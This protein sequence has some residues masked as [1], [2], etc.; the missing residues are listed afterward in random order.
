MSGAFLCLTAGLTWEACLEIIGHLLIDLFQG[1]VM[2]RLKFVVFIIVLVVVCAHA[3][4]AGTLNVMDYGA[5]ADRTTDDTA[6]IQAA[7]DESAKT[8]GSTVFMP[9]GKYRIEGTIHVREGVTLKGEF[10]GPATQIGTVLESV[11]GRGTDEGEGCIVMEPTST[12]S[13]IAIVY[14]EQLAELQ[15][16]IKYPFAVKVNMYCKVE[17]VGLFNPYQGLDLDFAHASMVRNVW[18]EPLKT[19]IY[20]DHISDV[21]R[22]ENVHFWPYFTH[23]KPLRKWVQQNGTAFEFGRSDWHY[24]RDCFSFGYKIGYQFH[25]SEEVPDVPGGNGGVTNG[26]FTG[27]GA[28]SCEIGVDVQSCHEVGISITNSMF[29]PFATR[30]SC[31]IVL[32]DTN[33]GNVTLTN[34]NFWEVRGNAAKVEGGALTL[35]ACNIHAWGVHDANEK[36][37]FDLV[38]GR[39]NVTGCTVNK[40]GWFAKLA[41]EKSR[42]MISSNMGMEHLYVTSSI[43][44]RAV[45]GANSPQIE[46]SPKIIGPD[47]EKKPAKDTTPAE[48]KKE[49]TPKDKEKPKDE[50]GEEIDYDQEP[51]KMYPNL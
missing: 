39:L 28:D 12:L 5:K 7:I 27:I 4:V 33:S 19:G 23:G 35:S 16:P 45:F 31:G 15:Q 6:A 36:P 20:A 10:S 37:A 46:G 3:A 13:G 44:R 49:D 34:C 24:M 30:D 21:C 41:G 40:D 42:A 22:I 48:D 14:P 18:G 47:E 25:A 11:K 1:G 8:V 50:N 51:W 26:Q 32:H 2:G 9:A 17:E 43:G 29:A 38:N